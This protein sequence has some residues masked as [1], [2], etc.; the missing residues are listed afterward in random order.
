[1]TD[2]LK[3]TEEARLRLR[4]SEQQRV[5]HFTTDDEVASAF[6]YGASNL[7]QDNVAVTRL[8]ILITQIREDERR[9]IAAELGNIANQIFNNQSK[10]YPSNTLD[11]IAISLRT[12]ASLE[13]L[14]AAPKTP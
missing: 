6:V 14:S 2:D 3:L 12:N 7:Y 9:K 10:E 5:S 8:K 1:M 11:R 13:F 4:A